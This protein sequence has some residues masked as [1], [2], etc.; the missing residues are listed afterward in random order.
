MPRKRR[1]YPA[2]LKAKVAVEALR[3]EATMA[4]LAARYDVHP[5]LIA[6]WKKTARQTVLAGFSGNHERQEASRET[7]V[8][9]LR[10]KDRR[11]RHRAGFFIEG[12]RSVS[13]GRRVEMVDP[14]HPRISIVRQCRLVSIA[15]SSFYYAGPKAKTRRSHKSCRSLPPKTR[16]NP[17]QVAE[18]LHAADPPLGTPHQQH[19][20]NQRQHRRLS[21]RD[22]PRQP[23]QHRYRTRRPYHP[24]PAPVAHLRSL[25]GDAGGASHYI[26][27]Y[28]GIS[29]HI[30]DP[31]FCSRAPRRRR[32]GGV[33]DLEDHQ[34]KR[35][36]EDVRPPLSF[37]HRKEVWREG[38]RA[39]IREL[40]PRLTTNAVSL[41]H[42]HGGRSLY[43]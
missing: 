36:L 3:E 21:G 39:S 1:S 29:R 8:K 28:L 15:R 38:G 4:E 16:R 14:N 40:W 42:P 12:L 43:T 19:R 9:E 32:G 10:G 6:H 2:E 27:A 26:P 41:T 33:E 7:E 5:N 17:Q 31:F 18:R 24:R 30:S 11:T 13:R 22:L 34:V 25:G 20:P 35:A 23:P 37:G